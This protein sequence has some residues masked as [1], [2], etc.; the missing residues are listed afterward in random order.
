MVDDT[1]YS[2]KFGWV[3]VWPPQDAELNDLRVTIEALKRQSGL[4]I[5]DPTII[6]PTA[7]RRHT[8]PAMAPKDLHSGGNE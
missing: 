4:A 5:A 1:R 7:S 3:C 8:S 6:S 2:M